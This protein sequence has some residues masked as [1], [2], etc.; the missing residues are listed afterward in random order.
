[1]AVLA[2]GQRKP[3]CYVNGMTK[4]R[5]YP[6]S[7]SNGQA[8]GK[9]PVLLCTSDYAPRLLGDIIIIVKVV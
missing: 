7:P 8:L 4:R 3:I 6:I 9:G 5:L 2:L 1:M